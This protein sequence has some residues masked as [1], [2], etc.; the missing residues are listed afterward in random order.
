[1]TSE[2]YSRCG[3]RRL[4]ITAEHIEDAILSANFMLSDWATLGFKQFELAELSI[5]LTPTVEQYT[6]P[7]GVLDIWDA[8]LIRSGVADPMFRIS[9]TDYEIIPKKDNTGKSDR[10][11]VDRSSAGQRTVYLWPV[12][13]RNTDVVRYTALRRPEDV[14]GMA[15]TAPIP[16]EWLEAFAS[17]LAYRLSIKY[18]PD[19]QAGLMALAQGDIELRGGAFKRAQFADRE[20]APAV[21]TVTHKN[22]GRR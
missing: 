11:Y 7:V 9:R 1:M 15:E 22:R 5:A 17:G 16:Y 2:A 4:A 18:A 19:R 3:I 21:F 6:L 10:Y 13:D 8:R 14:T 12:P 20:R